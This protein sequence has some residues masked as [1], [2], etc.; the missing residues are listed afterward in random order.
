MANG[1]PLIFTGVKVHTNTTDITGTGT[2][3][4]FNLPDDENITIGNEPIEV[5]VEGGQSILN[6]FDRELN[7][8]LYDMNVVDTGNSVA[9][10][11]QTNST[12]ASKGSIQLVGATG[13]PNITILNVRM[14]ASQ[15]FTDGLTRQHALLKATLRA[16][17]E[18]TVS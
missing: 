10:V 17:T 12:I 6:G 18:I 7:I 8:A 9:S 15:P 2:N 16:T 5:L 11:I 13:A 3:V 4:T 14:S 1:K